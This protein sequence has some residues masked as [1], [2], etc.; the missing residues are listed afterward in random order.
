[1]SSLSWRRMREKL[2][3]SGS[4]SGKTWVR[5]LG[6]FA[7]IVPIDVGAL[8]KAGGVEE[9]NRVVELVMAKDA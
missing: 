7:K 5:D 6:V 8:S 2:N 4:T 9:C 3:R 1:L